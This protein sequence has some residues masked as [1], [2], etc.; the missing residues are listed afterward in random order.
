[1]AEKKIGIR[2]TA[3]GDQARAELGRLRDQFIKTRNAAQAAGLSFEKMDKAGKAIRFRAAVNNIKDFSN[4]VVGAIQAIDQLVMRSVKMSG[5]NQTLKFSIDGAKKATMGMVD[6]LTLTSLAVEAQRAGVAKN[7]KEFERL[8]HVA[9]QTG[10]QIGRGPVESLERLTHG[11]AKNEQEILDELGVTTRA[12]DAYRI[13]GERI[14]KTA[15]EMSGYEKQT[16]QV[17]IRMEE[18]EKKMGDQEVQLGS[19]QKKWLEMRSNWEETVTLASKF[20]ELLDS[21]NKKLNDAGPFWKEVARGM[22]LAASGAAD[23]LEVM[24]KLNKELTPQKLEKGG[25]FGGLKNNLLAEWID[26]DLKNVAEADKQLWDTVGG[27][28]SEHEARIRKA[29]ELNKRALSAIE[30]STKKKKGAKK[31]QD[32]TSLS[33]D[34]KGYTKDD[35][36]SGKRGPL[37]LLFDEVE[38]QQRVDTTVA[39]LDGVNQAEEDYYQKHTQRQL[40]QIEMRKQ[41]NDARHEGYKQWKTDTVNLNKLDLSMHERARIRLKRSQEAF[42]TINDLV[43][44]GVQAVQLGVAATS[45]SEDRKA[46]IMNRALG[47]QAAGIAAIEVVR[48]AQA[49]AQYNI[50]GAVLHGAAAALATAK[51]VMLLTG[52]LDPHTASSTGGGGGG[53]GFGGGDKA[54]KPTNP[55]SRPDDA[56]AGGSAPPGGSANQGGG[57]THINKVEVHTLAT[58]DD[59]LFTKLNQGLNDVKRR[60]GDA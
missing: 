17:V 44:Q 55:I 8:A 49:A 7:S 6:S 1:M 13:Y 51:S 27:F 56:P 42:Q 23:L 21:I 15:D 30:D 10:L 47:A 57:G 40:M 38:A 19:F 25:A 59:E 29:E 53:G 14:G 18:L 22:T 54:S 11:L 46:R 52:K 33:I 12:E 3:K 31:K 32:K 60:V 43:G 5:V 26:N 9:T 34:Q 28:I 45:M 35:P 24:A 58:N 48:A 16:A 37:E 4:M 20:P 2:I 36:L 41:L 50:P 39:A